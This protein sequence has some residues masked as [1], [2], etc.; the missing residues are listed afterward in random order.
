[1]RKKAH[2]LKPSQHYF[3]GLFLGW[4]K[5]TRGRGLY[6]KVFDPGRPHFWVFLSSLPEWQSGRGSLRQRRHRAQ[7]GQL[8][9]VPAGARGPG[10]LL[11]PVL[12]PGLQLAGAPQPS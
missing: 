1:M 5:W 9:D 11:S 7:P 10:C 4:N 6:G 8:G 3:T 2:F 12:S